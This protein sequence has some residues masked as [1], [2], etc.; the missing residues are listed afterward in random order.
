M[1]KKITP[2]T[3]CKPATEIPKKVNK[4]SP[5]N[6][7]S[8]NTK[9][10]VITAFK[11]VLLLSRFVNSDVIDKKTGMI[12]MGF[13]RVRNEVKYSSIIV[14]LSIVDIVRRGSL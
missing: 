1:I 12:P 2:P 7:K 13:I 14:K 3:T 11:A 8:I 5:R 9:A 4:Y 6:A 10:A